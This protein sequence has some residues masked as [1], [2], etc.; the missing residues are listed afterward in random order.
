MYE[1]DDELDEVLES[2]R[3]LR[4]CT[5]WLGRPLEGYVNTSLWRGDPTVFFFE[6]DDGE[7]YAIERDDPSLC[8][9]LVMA[10]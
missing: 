1:M 9:E 4:I 3:R 2:E 6:T 8:V 7:V 5:S 10:L